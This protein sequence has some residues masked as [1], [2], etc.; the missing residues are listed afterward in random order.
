MVKL[1]PWGS[2]QVQDYAKLRDEF[3]I[4]VLGADAW[5]DVPN[6][7]PL[8]R[9]GVVFGHRGF[10]PVLGAIKRQEPF[11]LMTGL[12]PS[13]KMHLGHKAVLDQ[14]VW[15]QDQGA[16]VHVAIADF[17]AY[18]ARGFTIDEARRIGLE[19]YVLTYLALGMKPGK[20]EVYYQTKRSRV[21]DLAYSLG[22]HVNLSTL[23]AIYG[24]EDSWKLAHINAPLMQAAD[25]LHVQNR[26]LGGPRPVVVP[27]GVDQ[28]PHLRLTRDLAAAT[29]VFSAQKT[30]DGKFGVFI[31]PETPPRPVKELLDGAERI[32]RTD[33]GFADV[34]RNDKYRAIYLPA[35]TMDDLL[36][37]DLALGQWESTELGQAGYFPPSATYHRFM[38]GLLAGDDGRPGKMSSSKPETSIFLTDDPKTV[39]K[40]LM[41]AVT[42]GRATEEEQRKHG[43]DPTR[44]SVYEI[45]LYHTADDKLLPVVYDECTTGKRLCG[46]CKKQCLEL[47]QGQLKDLREKREASRHLVKEIVSDN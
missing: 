10:E 9:R 19:E 14:V 42:G 36:R 45:Y 27:V 30:A 4:G 6:A 16:D 22:L 26:D 32:L 15:Y 21:K 1:D 34:R 29:R 44:C 47:L 7:H 46:G 23:R 13:G 5:D 31:K 28:D 35:A 38:S 11:S 43:A 3:G 39:E 40:K 24:M 2:F 33:L 18:A 12:M 20:S 8:F 37:I 25:I 17:E 41:R